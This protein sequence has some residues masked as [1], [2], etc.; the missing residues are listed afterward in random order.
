MNFIRFVG[1]LFM[2]FG[3]LASCLLA[4]ALA[5]LMARSWPILIAVL[6]AGLLFELIT[7]EAGIELTA[8]TQS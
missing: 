1:L 7:T 6:L 8:T 4:V 3:I 5:V 2:F